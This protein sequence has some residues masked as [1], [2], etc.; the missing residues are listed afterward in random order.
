MVRATSNLNYNTCAPMKRR[1]FNPGAKERRLTEVDE[2]VEF[3]VDS[4]HV[5]LTTQQRMLILKD[6]HDEVYLP[7][8]VGSY[9][10]DTIVIGL[11]EIEIS[12]PQTTDLLKEAI[13]NLNAK[14]V[15]VEVTKLQ[16]ETYYSNIMIQSGAE[17]LRLDARPSDAIALAVRA[18][19]PIFVSREVILAAAIRPERDI[20][21]TQAYLDR[22]RPAQVDVNYYDE[23]F[24]SADIAGLNVFDDFLRT[25][26]SDSIGEMSEE[27]LARLMDEASL[28]SDSPA[29]GGSVSDQ[30]P[31]SDGSAEGD[32]SDTE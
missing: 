15:R 30:T 21:N 7:I 25:L 1:Y 17:V 26:D 28:G 20:R 12:R 24:S 3:A 32:S 22:V 14:V 27:E 23:P 13:E 31:D 11:Q 10:V 18:H 4:I 6:I 9:E 16:D 8:W 2:W 5:S 19:V 29:E